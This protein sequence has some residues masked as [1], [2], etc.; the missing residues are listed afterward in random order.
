MYT[1][2]GL[3]VQY[4]NNR[5]QE[6]STRFGCKESVMVFKYVVVINLIL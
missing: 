3:K 2:K 6:A 4:H 1:R 5:I